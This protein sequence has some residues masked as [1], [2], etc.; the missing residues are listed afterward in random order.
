MLDLEERGGTERLHPLTKFKLFES[1]NVTGPSNSI[2][3]GPKRPTS[4][5]RQTRPVKNH[6]SED[7]SDCS[8]S[9]TAGRL[10][11][12][13][14]NEALSEAAAQVEIGVD[15]WAEPH[16][17]RLF[18]VLVDPPS[19]LDLNAIEGLPIY[20]TQLSEKIGNLLENG[21]REIA[22]HCW[23]ALLGQCSTSN[24]LWV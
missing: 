13:L 16:I 9:N 4:R 2:P 15:G 12:L 14:A 23:C 18:V 3:Q 5:S 10:P 22:T 8:V 24:I 11:P 19:G 17:F 6:D 20:L 7:H 1:K 21:I